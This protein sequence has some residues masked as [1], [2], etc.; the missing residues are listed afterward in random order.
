MKTLPSSRGF[1]LIELLVAI[2]ILAIVAGVV[3]PK[4]LNV[5]SQA[6]DTVAKQIQSEL[7]T[8]YANWK[9]SGGTVTGIPYGSTL[10][11][12]LYAPIGSSTKT[13]SADG[14][15]TVDDA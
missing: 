6:E 3:V 1:S 11:Y 13:I 10:L 7:N 9:A 14:T 2:G 15:C 12:Q 8:T 4:F 5:Q